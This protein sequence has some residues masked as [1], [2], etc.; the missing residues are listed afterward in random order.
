MTR[1]L[2]SGCAGRMGREI[3]ALAAD[4]GNVTVVAGVDRVTAPAEFP[5]FADLGA[6]RVEA[7]VLVDFSNPSALPG[8]LAYCTKNKLPVLL[9]ATGYS[10]E[11]EQAVRE[12][13]RQIAVFRS[14]NMS[15][16]VN[17]LRALVQKACAALGADYDVE[18]LEMHHNQK[19][20]APS[21]TAK[22]LAE[23]A[24]EALPY[25]PEFVYDRHERRA[26][27]DRREIG[28]HSLRGGTVVGEHQVLFAGQ[29][30]VIT[31]SHS[32]GSRRVFAAGA[33][34]AAAFL[35]DKGP[36]LYTMEDLIAEALKTK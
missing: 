19:L 11:E 22:M 17:V 24:A 2:L 27:R 4:N 20:D 21:G 16:G 30:E 32:A 36:G 25:T 6:C 10:P 34:R 31:L 35:A 18:I 33:L 5:V 29:D 1:I 26:R 8:I 3:A 9:A 23:A 28:I 13:S 12:A 7:D 14:A 15:L